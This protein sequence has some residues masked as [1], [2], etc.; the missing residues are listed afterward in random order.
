MRIHGLSL[1][2]LKFL[3]PNQIRELNFQI[4][5]LVFECTAA[6]LSTYICTCSF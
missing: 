5:Y 2:V 6:E 3:L 4:S 1:M